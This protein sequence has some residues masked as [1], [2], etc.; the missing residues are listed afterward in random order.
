MSR[1][2]GLGDW[3]LGDVP[4]GRRGGRFECWGGGAF[5]LPQPKL[6]YARR[7]LGKSEARLGVTSPLRRAPLGDETL[8]VVLNFPH[9]AL[10]CH[11]ELCPFLS[12]R[13]CVPWPLPGWRSSLPLFP[14]GLTSLLRQNLSGDET[15]DYGPKL[16]LVCLGLPLGTLSIFQLAISPP[17]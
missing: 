13:L 7:P 16:P 10:G 2:E 9:S 11:W 6:D 3:P 1:P 12:G 8:H 5:W 14:P 4:F 15:L 17:A